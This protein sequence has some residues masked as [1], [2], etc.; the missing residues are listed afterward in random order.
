MSH[1]EMKEKGNECIG[2]KMYQ[3]AAGYYTAAL[4]DNPSSHTVYSNR[5]LAYSKLG[6]FDLALEDA[7]KCTELAPNF[8]RGYLRKSVAL[9]GLGEYEKAMTAAEE[10][11]KLRGSDA[12]CRNCVAQWLEANEALHKEKVEKCLQEIGFQNDVIPK[13]CRIISDDYLTIFLNVLLC[14]LQFTTTGV[15]V[16]FVSACILKLFL[17]LNRILQLFGHTGSRCSLEW[18]AALRLA[19]KVDPSTSRVPQAIVASLLKRST[20]FSTWLDTA[21]DHTLYPIVRPIMSLIMIAVNA[22]CI[23]LNVLNSEPPVTQVS[24]QA[25]LPFFENSILS[26][27]DYILQHIAVYKELLESYGI[28]NYIFTKQEVRFGEDCIQKLEAL[29]KQ[30]PVD[31]YSK[32]VCDRAMVSIA[33]ARI[34]LGENPGFDPV[35][36]APES[37]KAVSRIGKVDPEKLKVYVR[38]KQEILKSVLEIPIENTESALMESSYEDTQDL[39]CCTSKSYYV[40]CMCVWSLI[41]SLFWK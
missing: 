29:L 1:D 26:A 6:K 12:I 16:Q 13:G 24:C 40:S 8:A 30:C 15:E 3:E 4:K 33:L 41:S 38:N 20:E 10:G 14:R 5:S 11:Y 19:S 25:C 28:S 9:T 7:K 34:R 2:Q 39:L 17:E 21:V 37:G 23:S 31:G 35:A 36:Y 32:D 22:R 27:P 18:L